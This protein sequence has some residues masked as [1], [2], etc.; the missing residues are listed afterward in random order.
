MTYAL[1]TTTGAFYA[2]PHE[3][4]LYR[5]TDSGRTWQP[6]ADQTRM[7]A[8]PFPRRSQ[9]SALLPDC[10]LIAMDPLLLPTPPDPPAPTTGKVSGNDK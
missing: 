4:D 3:G 7:R 9:S 10:M 1:A 2:A 6:D 8:S 5:S